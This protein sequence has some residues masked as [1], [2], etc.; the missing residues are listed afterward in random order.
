[1]TSQDFDTAATSRQLWSLALPTFGQL[2]AEP[3]FVLIDTAIVGHISTA[4]LAGLSVGSTIILTAVGLCNFLAYSTTAHVAKLMGAGKEKE[5]LR[6]G[7]DGTWLALAIGLVLSLLLFLFAQPLC[8]AIGAK[9]E[10]LGQAVLYTKAVVLGAPGMLMVYAVNGIFRGMQEA[11]ITLWAA[12]F[13]AGLN[14]ILDFAFIYGAHMGILGSGLATCLAQWAM[15]LVLVIP[16]FL[17]ARS[18]Q[19]SLLPSRQGLARNAFQGLPLFARTLALRM[20]MVATVVAAAS[21][22]TQVLASYQA[23]NS[24][25]NFALNTL[26]SV[27]IAGQALVGTALGAK[28]V[29]ETR[30]L[31]K[32]IA[33]SGALSGLAVGLVFACL[34]L[35]GAGLFSPQ[36]PVQALISLS[37]IIV[38]FFFPLQGWMWALDGILIGAGD[39]T[40]LAGA[41]A[42]AAGAHVVA[43]IALA[44]ALSFWRVDSAG[45]KVATLWLTF[46]IVLMGLRAVA[47]GKRATTDTWIRAAL[48]SQ[49]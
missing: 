44:R 14:T 36:A 19:V 42:A 41:C 38:A 39:F 35:W 32:L 47:N 34:G 24:A 4:A 46:N 3:A 8:S 30:F 16:A 23:V 26:D 5:G 12:V 33:R 49:E 40:Y 45:I 13:G 6:S 25:W 37:M 43:L 31:T 15:S 11:S 20:A 2:V 27:A 22:G 18:Q 29:G 28:D 10:A 21:M 1:M 7:V 9:G 17:K 48:E